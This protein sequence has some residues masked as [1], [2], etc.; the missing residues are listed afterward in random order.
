MAAVAS[1]SARMVCVAIFVL[2]GA[3]AALFMQPL[4]ATGGMR[5]AYR[6]VTTHTTNCERADTKTLGRGQAKMQPARYR[7]RYAPRDARLVRE[8]PDAL[9]D[10]SA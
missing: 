9:G 3:A 6:L 5:L 8:P 7:L 1:C 4:R 2:C 10:A